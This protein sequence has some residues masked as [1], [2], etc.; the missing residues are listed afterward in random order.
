MVPDP[1]VHFPNA[2]GAD[3]TRKV[4]AEL[5]VEHRS[6]MRELAR[7]LV[8]DDH[9][10]EDVVQET[11]LAA[12]RRPPRAETL[13]PWLAR[14]VRNIALNSRRAEG[15]R[16]ARERSIP[17]PL[18]EPSPEDI[19][20]R[21]RTQGLVVAALQDLGEAYR[22]AL[23]LRFYE[24]LPPR[25]IAR[26][27]GIP[28][29][30][31]RSRI[32]RGLEA[33]RTRL[34][35]EYGG[36][37][38]SW[39]VA[40]VPWC[41]RAREAV[42]R[43][44]P[45]ALP[46]VAKGAFLSL[47]L[48]VCVVVAGLPP[49][50]PVRGIAASNLAIEP[51]V[52]SG[53]PVDR[54]GE[55][56]IPS[57]SAVGLALA[58]ARTCAPQVAI[59][60]R[61]IDA[62]TGEPIPRLRIE[63]CQPGGSP[64]VVTTALDG[65]FES[66]QAYGPGELVVTFAQRAGGGELPPG[67]VTAQ[68][69][70][71]GGHLELP[72]EIGPTYHVRADLPADVAW[73]DFSAFL[74]EGGRERHPVEAVLLTD[75]DE[76]TVR[77]RFD[78]MPALSFLS[79]GTRSAF[80][81]ELESFD[82]FW[83]GNSVVPASAGIHREAAAVEWRECGRVRGSLR[84][85]TGVPLPGVR[86]AAYSP[87]ARPRTGLTG[88]HGD[89]IL[90]PLPPGPWR[91]AITD[92]RYASNEAEIRVAPGEEAVLA[93]VGWALPSTSIAGRLTSRTGTHLPSGEVVLVDPEHPEITFRAEPVVEVVG[94]SVSATFRFEDVPAGRYDLI[95]PM[96][97]GFAWS[98][99][100]IRVT[101]QSGDHEFE[102]RDDVPA[103]D[104]GF[105][106]FDRSTGQP[107]DDARASFLIDRYSIGKEAA[108][109]TGFDGDPRPL[110][111]GAVALRGIPEGVP[112]HWIVEHEGYRVAGGDARETRGGRERIVDVYLERAWTASFRIHGVAQHG[113]AV[114]LSGVRLETVGGSLLGTSLQD[115]SLTVE[116]SYDPGRVR[117]VLEGWTVTGWEGFFMGRRLRELDEHAVRMERP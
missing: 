21:L 92:G 47:A 108:L 101:G 116:L 97:D 13:R 113:R 69:P 19:V 84:G 109:R 79:G 100:R 16:D 65:R 41:G 10:A 43:A 38:G 95:P 49:A 64:E 60:G 7:R 56:A 91:V 33:L 80:E 51:A 81:L 17:P 74:R 86:L 98:P 50:S 36:D 87:D 40:L 27:L 76:R 89:F 31:V 52:P 34:D 26:R 94:E 72:V 28:V 117:L 25:E 45:R 73:S 67:P 55:E 42:P 9:R 90:G 14:V 5:L 22:S 35:S 68:V 102:C 4:D 93:L 63:L 18:D 75:F 32:R 1:G 62:R 54:R 106:V 99:P 88:D 58:A 104:L 77:V 85:R 3:D 83:L 2:N 107:L 53:H 20:A 110:V 30:T 96:R 24:E 112:A 11:C 57:R 29:E 46:H 37:R 6:F 103:Y 78:S 105:R 114:P 70:I 48:S 111:F 71:G 23:Y 66:A 115:G 39:C 44:L 15:R 59:L 12:L 61:A 8:M 82:R